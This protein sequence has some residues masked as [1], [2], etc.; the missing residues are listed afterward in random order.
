MN[1]NLFVT[2]RNG[3]KEPID[4]EKIHKVIAW[5]AEWLRQCFG[6]SS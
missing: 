5:A 2:K 1:N 6:I 4:L 3:S